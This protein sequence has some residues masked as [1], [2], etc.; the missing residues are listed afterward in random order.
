M[1]KGFSHHMLALT[2]AIAAVIPVKMG[3]C[4]GNVTPL[5]YIGEWCDRTYLKKRDHASEPQ[6]L[7]ITD[8]TLVF[9]RVSIANRLSRGFGSGEIDSMPQIMLEQPLIS[10]RL[11]KYWKGINDNSR[12]P[13]CCGNGSGQQGSFAFHIAWSTLCAKLVK[14]DRSA[15]AASLAAMDLGRRR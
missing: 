13:G 14:Q 7:H 3:E 5:V 1:G 15:C 6:I 10:A 4:E 9:S 8:R 12:L 2:D 11:R